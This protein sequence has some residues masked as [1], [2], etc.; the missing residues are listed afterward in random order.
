MTGSYALGEATIAASSAASWGSR[1]D[2]HG[3]C[4]LLPLRPPQPSWL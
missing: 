3:G 4:F 1:T 2:A